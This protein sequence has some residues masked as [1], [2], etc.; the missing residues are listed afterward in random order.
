MRIFKVDEKIDSYTAPLLKVVFSALL[1]AALLAIRIWVPI[2]SPVWD[3]IVGV[4]S[5]MLMLLLVLR[6]ALSFC[7]MLLLS[8]RREK[9]NLDIQAAIKK[10]KKCS[11]DYVISLLE[12]NDI[13]DVAIFLG[14]RVVR[15]GASSDSRQGESRLFGKQYYID[16]KS[17]V[18]IETVRETLDKYSENDELC[19]ISIDGLIPRR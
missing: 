5:A 19:V 13:I 6:I 12:S 16:D 15:F 3:A 7:E 1:I 14:G 18:A 11:V 2:S 17:D 9:A 8:E 10:S 4:A